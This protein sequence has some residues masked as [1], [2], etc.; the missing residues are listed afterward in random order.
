[1]PILIRSLLPSTN[2]SVSSRERRYALR[3]TAKLQARSG[4]RILFLYTYIEW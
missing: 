3:D 2:R 1:M 4:L